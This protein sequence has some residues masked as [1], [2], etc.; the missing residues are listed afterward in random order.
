VTSPGLRCRIHGGKSLAGPASPSYKHGRYSR[1][2]PSHLVE[3]YQ[4]AITDPELLALRDEIALV[5]VRLAALLQR[6]DTGETTS[7]WS[8]L[9]A[10]HIQMQQALAGEDDEVFQNAFQAL[11]ATIECGGREDDTWI[12]INRQ[13]EQRRKLV[14]SERK[15]LVE[16]QQMIT[17]EQAMIL[18][19]AV[20]D[21][22]RQN[23]TDRD[24][25][26][27]ISTGIKQ[28][29]SAG[30]RGGVDTITG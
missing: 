23:V 29:V 6:I 9:L 26:A 25:L 12:A 16:M 7:L 21:V 15:R 19:T 13:L 14:E 4:E 11:G 28:L 2:L 30:P 27:S 10:I 17:A 1:Y 3:R 18:L 20:V 5:D 22:I 24:T 8:K